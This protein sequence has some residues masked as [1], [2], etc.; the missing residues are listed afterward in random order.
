[1]TQV[2]RRFTEHK[3]VGNP[4]NLAA[5]SGPVME[6]RTRYPKKVLKPAAN[7]NVLKGGV[8]NKKIGSHV[9][10]GIWAGLPI[11]TL[12]LQERATCWSGCKHYR[13][14]YGNKMHLAPRHAHGPELEVAIGRQLEQLNGRHPNGFTVRLHVLGDFYSVEYVNAWAEWLT[15]YPRLRVFGYTAWPPSSP[16]GTA[17][18]ALVEQH[19]WGRAAIRFSDGGGSHRCTT[20]MNATDLRGRVEG[21]IVCPVQSGDAA[22]CGSC[23]LCWSTEKNVVFLTH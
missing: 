7:T 4:L 23:T 9:S 3:P 13:D 12:T 16:V 22:C 14:C 6:G 20:S 2:R 21:G 19:G 1:M 15:Q 10:K 18:A 5:S 8:N 17:I 11:Y